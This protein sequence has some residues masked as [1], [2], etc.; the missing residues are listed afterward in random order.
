MATLE[1]QYYS[2]ALQRVTI[3]NVILPEINKREPGVGNPGTPYKTLYLLHGLSGDHTNWTRKTSIERYV[4][5]YGIAVVMPNV[6]RS[7]Y[8]DTQYN[9][10][11]LTFVA[12]E[13]PQ[14]CRGYF[15]GM[16]DKREDNYVAGLSMGGYGAV[17]IA[18][19]YPDKFCGCATLS[20][21]LD[22]TRKN[23][24][25]DLQ[26]WR[27]IFGFDLK[28]GDD[29]AGT[30]HDVYAL[31]DK[32]HAAGIP[33]PKL[34]VWCGTE[35]GLIANNRRFRDQLNALGIAHSYSESEGDHSWK[36]WDLHIQDVLEFFFG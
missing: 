33:F 29:L 18:L 22:I 31:V 15:A 26:A 32:N 25:I 17:K 3:V 12:E 27:A 8:T 11:Y 34:F 2:K 24:P 16:S 28:S 9:E 36:W 13:L 30:K 6:G 4:N 1:F 23:R 35:D 19:T 10:N 20:G 5:K 21:A 7:W 14:V